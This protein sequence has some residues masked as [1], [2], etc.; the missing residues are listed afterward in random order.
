M[1]RRHDTPSFVLQAFVPPSARDA[2][3]AVRAFNVSIATVADSV[4]NKTVGAM[5]ME[6]WR[7]AIART[8]EGSPPRE[9][10]T[11]LLAHALQQLQG[12]GGRM[13][14]SWFNRVIS[15]RDRY[16][17]N[18]PFPSLA[19]LETYAESTYSTLTYLTLS[20]LPLHSVT[21]DHLASHL[22][23]A[24]GIVAVLR[25]LPLVAF[26]TRERHHSNH[27][28]VPRD[29]FV[30]EG[31]AGESRRGTITLP[32]DVMAEAG[33][34]E[35]D[36]F[37]EGASAAGLKD[38]VFAVATRANDHLITAREMLGR[39]Q[40]GQDA[41]HDFEHADDHADAHGD[42]HESHHHEPAAAAAAT[43]PSPSPRSGPSR[44]APTTTA[45]AAAAE[46][47]ERAFGVLLHA[48]PTGMWLDRLERAD[49]D[50]FR[51]EL[52]RREWLLPWKAYWAFYR[53][54]F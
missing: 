16:L 25:G 6:F 53:R 42:A 34:R 39:I 20:A 49:F 22:G 46:E 48:L 29:T 27:A 8:F 2:Y 19:S 37:R 3:L 4:S 51:P 45:V 18:R 7:E 31:G 5:R 35:E 24:S 50:V 44:G 28:A 14:Q 32:L 9:P 36:V 10:V 26:P 13:N 54:R 41:G 30:A 21:A 15:A 23:K 11:R 47:V 40:A 33:L 12:H 43:A 1:P 17:D 52:R 38:A